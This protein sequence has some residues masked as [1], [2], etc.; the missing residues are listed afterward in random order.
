M[1]NL[2]T[3]KVW[4]L[5]NWTVKTLFLSLSLLSVGGLVQANTNSQ[6]VKV[7]G[8][9]S[10]AEVFQ[11]GLGQAEEGR[12]DEAMTT[13][14]T[15]YGSGDLIP[16]LRRA[17]QNNIGVI[18]IKQKK[19]DEA[20]NHLDQALKEDRQIAITM[21]N[22]NK[23]YTFEAQQA[24]KKVFKKTPVNPPIGELLYFD[25]K[26][27]Q[28]PNEN[29]LVA[30]AKPNLE[31]SVKEAT[32]NWRKAWTNQDIKGYLSFY[33]KHEFIPKNGKSLDSWKKGRHASVTGPKFIKVKTDKLE[34]MPIS[35]NLVRVKFYQRYHSDRFK[36][37][38]H[39]VLLWHKKNGHW[40]IIQEVVI[41]GVS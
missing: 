33:D 11:L 21:E 18:L 1:I 27:A 16:E 31:E 39:K 19:F 2:K 20:R 35:N 41:Y 4:M 15:L 25:I 26:K 36:D 23:I 34:V 30:K 9:S 29:V 40:K 38:I 3:K 8:L 6:N 7:D 5:K 32:E 12:L 13:W 37:D 14:R 10:Q 22:L 24:Y 17:L 28:I